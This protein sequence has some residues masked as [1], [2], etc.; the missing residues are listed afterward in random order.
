M[1]KTLRLP[2]RFKTLWYFSKAPSLHDKLSVIGF[3]LKRLFNVRAD[4]ELKAKIDP[5]N[6]IINFVPSQGELRPY[7]DIF[8]NAGFDRY[9]DFAPEN[10]GVV[11]DC[12]ANIGLFTLRAALNRKTEVFSFEP[13]PAVFKR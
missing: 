12:G 2:D 11:F 5:N 8:L 7:N 9:P 4:D 6:L 1:E 13:N 3:F 10:C